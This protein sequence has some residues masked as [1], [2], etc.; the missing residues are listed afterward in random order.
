[1]RCGVCLFLCGSPPLISTGHSKGK[2]IPTL[3]PLSLQQDESRRFCLMKLVGT[4]TCVVCCCHVQY[5]AP[6][7][8]RVNEGPA[9]L[10]F[11]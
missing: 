10:Y 5:S 2:Q 4:P 9:G 3:G 7:Q 1:M 6:N 8:V 11:W